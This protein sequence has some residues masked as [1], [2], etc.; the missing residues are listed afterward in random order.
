LAAGAGTW[1]AAITVHGYP[2][3]KYEYRIRAWSLNGLLS[4]WST[5]VVTT[6]AST[7]A[8][9]LAFK[10]LYVLRMDGL[11]KGFDSPPVAT[12][13]Y[14]PGQNEARAAHPLPGAA[15]PSVG[16]VLNMHGALISYGSRLVLHTSAYWPGGD[17]A[18]DFAFLPSG[19]GGY[20]LDRNGRL[21][22]FAVGSNPMPP[23][24]HGSP[25]WPGRDIA[26]K[27]V[28]LPGGAGGY[29]LDFTGVVSPFAIG[30]SA[31]PA[32][33]HLTR[34]W[35]GVDFARDIVLIPST[36]SGYVVNG[37]G[38][39]YPF[40]A[41][42]ETAPVVPAGSPYWYGH[43]VARGFFMLPASTAAAPGGYIQDCAGGLT[44]WGNAPATALRGS[45]R[46]G[47]AKAVTGG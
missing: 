25:Y 15:S 11:M 46:C 45:M 38:G 19:T 24:A 47:Q 2:G 39:L 28:M 30:H 22:P 6:V 12:W 17:M 44:P 33:P 36:A 31:V 43:N 41:P 20:V 40:T 1:T 23:A 42:G 26:R 8:S 29:V 3:H 34:H 21:W 16:A 27:V 7:A 9:P 13:Q 32:K 18:R 4:N 5:P 10:G 14:W 35:P 37:Y